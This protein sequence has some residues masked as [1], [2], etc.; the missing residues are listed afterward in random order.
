MSS[1]AEACLNIWF[2]VDQDSRLIYRAS[3]R[4]YALTGTDD[5][6]HLVLNSL[7]ASDFHLARHFSLS[8]YKT[9]IV[10]AHGR[11]HELPGFFNDASFEALFPDILE[12][13]CKGLE[14][15]F[16]D[17]PQI[18]PT[19]SAVYK[20]QIPKEPYYV[21][22]FLMEDDSGGLTALT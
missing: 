17:Q 2:I 11:Q 1:P 8:K 4:A 3:A 5:D 15:E 9:T 22:T 18:R 20:L 21:L 14:E 13:I 16:P 10:E 12:T 19:G 6:K 7:A